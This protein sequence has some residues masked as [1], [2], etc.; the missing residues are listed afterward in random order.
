M[1]S[2]AV[3]F[4]DLDRNYNKFALLL[5]DFEEAVNQSTLCNSGSGKII[6]HF[7]QLST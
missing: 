5:L 3:G 4:D 6:P 2:V 7:I 1:L